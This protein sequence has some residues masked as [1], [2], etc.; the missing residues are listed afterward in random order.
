MTT[1]MTDN[2]ADEDAT[3]QTMGDDADDGNNAATNI[4]AATQMMR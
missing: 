4:N 1:Q 2:N 3:T